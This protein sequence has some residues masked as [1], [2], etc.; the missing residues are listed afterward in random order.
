MEAI[1]Y[2]KLPL[3]TSKSNPLL[4]RFFRENIGVSQEML[5]I[6]RRPGNVQNLR[7]TALAKAILLSWMGPSQLSG[8]LGYNIYQGTE[9]NL[10][11]NVN[12]TQYPSATWQGGFL[13]APP[14]L[15]F[16]IGALVTGTKYGFFVSAYTSLLEGIKLQVIG[17]PS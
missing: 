13:G 14:T 15:S 16:T 3:N 8:I 1:I 11:Q 6:R 4:E 7:A 2:Y 9:S 5:G 10:I 12:A 17:T